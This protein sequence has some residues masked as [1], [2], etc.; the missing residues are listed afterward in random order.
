MSKLKR[1]NLTLESLYLRPHLL[2]THRRVLIHLAHTPNLTCSE[3][4]ARM[5]VKNEWHVRHAVHI[6]MVFGKI[7]PDMDIN[8]SDRGPTD[9]R[10][11]YSICKESAGDIDVR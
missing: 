5:G 10:T 6:L 4:A 3:L 2:P 8:D 11:R 9:P 7:V 1:E